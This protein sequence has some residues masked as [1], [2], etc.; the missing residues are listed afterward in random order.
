MSIRNPFFNPSKIPKNHPKTP[1]FPLPTAISS[2]AINLQRKIPNP[3]TTPKVEWKY[4][5]M[6]SKKLKINLRCSEMSSLTSFPRAN[7]N[8]PS[9]IPTTAGLCSGAAFSTQQVTTQTMRRWC[10]SRV[11]DRAWVCSGTE[12]RETKDRTTT[13]ERTRINQS[14]YTI[15][16]CQLLMMSTCIIP[17]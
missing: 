13:S 10:S 4:R 3:K 8:N 9:W 15:D 12:G 11:Q 7:N 2:P 1:S 5:L 6:K 14:E 16:F 17:I